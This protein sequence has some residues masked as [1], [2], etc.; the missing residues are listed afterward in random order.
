MMEVWHRKEQMAGDLMPQSILTSTQLL[1]LIVSFIL[2]QLRIVGADFIMKSRWYTPVISQF[3]LLLALTRP[4]ITNISTRW[5]PFYYPL[6]HIN[7]QR[8]CF[9][10]NSS[11]SVPRF[12]Q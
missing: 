3:R 7:H 5:T 9:A 12:R 11:H 1:R 6:I 8:R 10:C 4:T 2:I